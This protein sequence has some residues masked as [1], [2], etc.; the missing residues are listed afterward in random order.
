V[1]GHDTRVVIEKTNA[2]QVCGE[3]IVQ[4]SVIGDHLPSNFDLAV[5]RC[6]ETLM[7]RN[8]QNRQQQGT[9]T[10]LSTDDLWHQFSA[11]KC[12]SQEAN[13]ENSRNDG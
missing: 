1:D 8:G 12:D 3:V 11:L 10:S 2:R 4:R 5:K 9:T 6:R 7:R 13:K